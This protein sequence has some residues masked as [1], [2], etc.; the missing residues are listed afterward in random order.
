MKKPLNITDYQ[1]MM[2]YTLFKAALPYYWKTRE[3]VPDGVCFLLM[4]NSYGS[5]QEA[6]ND[7]AQHWLKTPKIKREANRALTHM[8]AFKELQKS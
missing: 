4:M 1:E 6:C 3:E 7:I 2:A 8:Q 5:A